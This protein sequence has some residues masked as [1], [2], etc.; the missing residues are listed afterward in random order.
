MFLKLGG[1]CHMT[2]VTCSHESA[3][4]AEQ[5]HG[6]EDSEGRDGH[7]GLGPAGGLP[8]TARCALSIL[9]E[10]NMMRLLLHTFHNFQ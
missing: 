9:I 8:H 10:A 3:H 6:P 5:Q 4:L 2:N 1:T 7:V